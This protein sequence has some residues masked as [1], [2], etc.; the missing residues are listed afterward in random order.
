ML[1]IF[2]IILSIIISNFSALPLVY[3]DN[4]IE[5]I[6]AVINDISPCSIEE[7]S[8]FDDLYMKDYYDNIYFVNLDENYGRNV[9]GSCTQ[10]A[11]AQLFAF[12]DTYWDDS[13]IADQ[14]EA[15]VE[16]ANDQ[17]AFTS[18]SPGI[19]KEPLELTSNLSAYDYYWNVVDKYADQYFHLLMIKIGYEQ[20]GYYDFND[21]DGPCGLSG[22]NIYKIAEKYLYYY[23]GKSSLEYTIIQNGLFQSV[24]KFTISKVKE[25]IPVLVRAKIT[26]GGH[27]MVAYDYDENNDV[28]YFHAGWGSSSSHRSEQSLGLSEYWD[29]MAIVPN[30]NHNHTH[31]D[32]YNR[33]SEFGG[34]ESVC[35]CSLVIP[36][37]VQ[38]MNNFLDT[39]PIV[40]W[41]SLI[42]D[43]WF[44]SIELCHFVSI[45]NKNRHEVFR[46]YI[47]DNKYYM[48]NEC[49]QEAINVPGN[50]YYIYVG[51]D[52]EMGASW[53]DDYALELVKEPN[54]YFYKNSILP[55]DW[56]FAGR[57]YFSNELT[58]EKLINEP[59]RK[60][61]T[62]TIG[63]F[64]INTE[65]LRCGY[66]ENSFIV[67]SP[68][69]ENA[70]RAYFEMN[71]N[72]AVYSFMYRACMWSSSENLD[73]IAII[74]VKDVSGNWTTL[75]DIPLSQLK[76]KENGV[77]QFIEQTEQGI[78]GIRFETTAT[79]TG[80]RNKGRLCIDDIV[81]STTSGSKNNL[82]T[83]YNYST[84]A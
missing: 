55:N 75:K 19:K 81:L 40:Y 60:N 76:T 24:R 61:T 45:L 69:R 78:F 11:L 47:M 84:K 10:L 14:Y 57:Y 64:A 20:F 77:T 7:T 44:E 26:G 79:A 53:D 2:M 8:A 4:D 13:I 68:R 31:T 42:K 70:G 12:L 51:L 1:K 72:Q 5:K 21:N 22:G 73:G 58:T 50:E 35:P 23:L 52:A 71:F 59:E 32:N 33:D 46:E 56:G 49:L 9:K 83:E 17:R 38:L 67:L 15:N 6:S 25:G 39:R 43:R 36:T 82:Y 18:K 62:L 30:T 65:R 27:A 74:Q 80:N 28:L 3:Q 41:D 34:K 29:A 16:I 66:I 37:K 54:R 63:D 48:S